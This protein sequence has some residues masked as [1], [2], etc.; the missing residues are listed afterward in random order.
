MLRR[1][2]RGLRADRDRLTAIETRLAGAHSRA[3][4]GGP[5]TIPDVADRPRY[6]PGDTV[7][8]LSLGSTGTVRSVPATG[9]TIEV[10]IGVMRA[11]VP[12]ADLAPASGKITEPQVPVPLRDWISPGEPHREAPPKGWGPIES[13]IE[14][15]GETVDEATE[16][17]DRYL[18]DTYLAGVQVVRVIHGKGTGALRQAV[19]DLVSDHPL[20]RSYRNAE[21]REGGE[22]ATILYLASGH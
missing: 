19:R 9:E 15:R 21:P 7:T 22:G 5:G 17:L 1:E 11:Q 13:Q 3:I 20:V 2:L 16:R 4:R 10:E 8:I 6:R 18:N 12:I 14:L